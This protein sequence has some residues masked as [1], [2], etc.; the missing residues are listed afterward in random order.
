[1]KLVPPSH[2]DHGCELLR[3]RRVDVLQ[4]ESESHICC[5]DDGGGDEEVSD[6]SKADVD[7]L[8]AFSKLAT[9]AA[10]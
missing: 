7:S 10:S 5:D 2:V 3:K 8:V 6:Q 4:R 9:D 1:M